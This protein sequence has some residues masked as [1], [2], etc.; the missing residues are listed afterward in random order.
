MYKVVDLFAGAGGLSLGFMQTQKYDI[1]VAFENSPYMQDTY[2]LNHPGVTISN[3]Y[4]LIVKTNPFNV[5]IV[6]TP[7]TFCYGKYRIKFGGRTFYR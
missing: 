7:V 3:L 4:E 5:K 6:E 2:R 1:K